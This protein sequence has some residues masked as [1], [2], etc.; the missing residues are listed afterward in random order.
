MKMHEVLRN[1]CPSAA[2]S[3]ITSLLSELHARNVW[4]LE[5]RDFNRV[6]N[7]RRIVHLVCENTDQFML[8][9]L[10]HLE[11]NIARMGIDC[12][13]VGDR[14]DDMYIPHFYETFQTT[15]RRGV[16]GPAMEYETYQNPID[17]AEAAADELETW[18]YN[19]G[20]DMSN[21]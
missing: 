3:E 14:A 13:C 12:D 10:Q 5:L 11:A 15:R 1:R 18:Y 16:L 6:G 21:A 2:V 7:L 20:K 17:L 19:I 4:V 9:Y 8:K